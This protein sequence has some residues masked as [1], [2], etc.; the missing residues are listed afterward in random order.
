MGS[1]KLLPVVVSLSNRKAQIDRTFGSM[2]W[3]VRS[4]GLLL[5]LR[6]NG[7]K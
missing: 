1:E 5:R 4:L 2:A 3:L 6:A 7:F